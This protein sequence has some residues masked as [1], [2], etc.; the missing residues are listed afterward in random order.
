M[1]GA[2]YD[3]RSTDLLH[4]ISWKNLNDRQKNE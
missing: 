4:A 2:N 1:T 3:V